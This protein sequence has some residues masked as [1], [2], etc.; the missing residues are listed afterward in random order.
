MPATAVGDDPASDLAVIRVDEPR[1]SEPGLTAAALG[2][3]Q[4]LRVG[5]VVIAIGAP[6]LDSVDGDG[7]CRRAL[8][9]VAAV[10]FRAAD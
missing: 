9:T 2:D 8:G 5:Q 1:M 10:V 4:Q 6:D 3:S 7:G